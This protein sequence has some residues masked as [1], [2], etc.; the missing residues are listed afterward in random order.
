MMENWRVAQLLPFAMT[1]AVFAAT[2]AVL[3]LVGDDIPPGQSVPLAGAP[4]AI[5]AAGVS[6]ELP[7]Q[8]GGGQLDGPR[9]FTKFDLSLL[10]LGA[11]GV[12]GFGLRVAGLV[13]ATPFGRPARLR[14]GRVARPRAGVRYLPVVVLGLIMLTATTALAQPEP[15]G[16]PYV[17]GPPDADT[18][19]PVAA[20]PYVGADPGG[21]DGG[22][23]AGVYVDALPEITGAATPTAARLVVG[24][25]TLSRPPTGGE[26]AAVSA[27]T[28]DPSGTVG[29]LPV[30]VADAVGLALLAV[31]ALLV[32]LVPRRCR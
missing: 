3:R 6:R 23:Y 10:A 19:P 32:V 9:A 13:T 8:P 4:R 5:E 29:S 2:F 28:E 22:R 24:G 26:P 12:I 25:A 30:T 15:N 31:A 1:A 21:A 16:A 7:Q 18:G 20:A 14:A 17:G 11:L 27:A